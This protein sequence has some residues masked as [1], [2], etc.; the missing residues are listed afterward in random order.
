MECLGDQNSRG[1]LQ[2]VKSLPTDSD[3]DSSSFS[4]LITDPPHLLHWITRK[5]GSKQGSENG[6]TLARRDPRAH[7]GQ[8]TLED[9]LTNHLL[10]T[11]YSLGEI[12]ING[13]N[14]L[15]FWNIHKLAEKLKVQRKNILL[16][17]HLSQWAN[18]KP[19]LPP[20]SLHMF[21]TD[22]GHFPW[23][24]I[25]PPK[26]EYHTDMLLPLNS[27]DSYWEFHH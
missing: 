19:H 4:S 11:K 10:C 13:L 12:G 27:S 8:C 17:N 3:C 16:L 6:K 24:Q 25:Q 20:N 26:S 14:F 15:I 7:P 21:S 18:S 9:C 5:S 23:K 2:V 1:K 22:K